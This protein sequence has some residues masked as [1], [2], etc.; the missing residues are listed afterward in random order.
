MI[1][2]TTID[3]LK[4]KKLKSDE[5]HDDDDEVEQQQRKKKNHK[6]INYTQKFKSFLLELLAMRQ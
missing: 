3:L 4:L 6:I 5:D 1:A 2:T